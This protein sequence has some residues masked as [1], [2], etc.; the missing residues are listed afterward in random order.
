M[1]L[2]IDVTQHDNPFD[3]AIMEFSEIVETCTLSIDDLLD[4]LEIYGL[5]VSETTAFYAHIQS[6]WNDNRIKITVGDD[7]PIRVKDFITIKGS[8]RC[9]QRF[10]KQMESKLVLQK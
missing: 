4:E 1:I 8:R 6:A 7:V 2:V 9:Q 5:S 10:K 3:K